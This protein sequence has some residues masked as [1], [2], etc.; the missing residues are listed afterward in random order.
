M[1]TFHLQFEDVINVFSLQRV[2]DEVKMGSSVHD[3]HFAP[4]VP[5]GSSIVG[6]SIDPSGVING[7]IWGP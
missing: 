7:G 3:Y 5:S 1:S 6:L 2:I 4:D